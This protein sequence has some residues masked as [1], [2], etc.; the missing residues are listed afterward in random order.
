MCVTTVT[1]KF[2]LPC[3]VCTIGPLIF[4]LQ[5]DFKCSNIGPCL[6]VSR[7]REHPKN[8]WRKVVL[9]RPSMLIV[10]CSLCRYLECSNFL[11]EDNLCTYVE[12]TILSM[13]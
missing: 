13:C 3:N 7:S 9:A 4:F 2:E 6:H 11:V 5:E 8:T 10:A 1:F 12:S